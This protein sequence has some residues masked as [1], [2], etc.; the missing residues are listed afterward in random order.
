MS[1]TKLREAALKRG[2]DLPLFPRK[3]VLEPLD[4]AGGFRPIAFRLTN[5]TAETTWLHPDPSHMIWR[6]ERNFEPWEVHG[7]TFRDESHVH[8]SEGYSPWQLLYFADALDM[9]HDRVRV[10]WVPKDECD[11]AQFFET[12]RTSLS[13]RLQNFDEEWTPAIKLLTAMQPRLWPFRRQRVTLLRDP[14]RTGDIDQVEEVAPTFDP[15]AFLRRFEM[16]L[17]ELALLHR[18]FVAE[19]R[20]LDPFPRWY[21][22]TEV[23][24]RRVTDEMTGISLRARDLYDAAWVLRGLYHLATDRWL[25]AADELDDREVSLRR[26][27]LPRRNQIGEPRRAQLKE[28]LLHEGLYPH[29]IHFF[30][31][32]QT[33]EIVLKRLLKLL[34]FHRPGSGVAVTNMRGV[35]QAQRHEVLFRSATEVAA[36]TV[37]IGD[38]EG[39]LSKVLERLRRDGLFPDANDVLLWEL[40]GRPADFEEANFSEA[41]LLRAVRS[42]ARRRDATVDIGLTVSDLREERARQTRP[43]RPAPALTKLM[44]KMAEERGARISKPELANVLAD[45]LVREIRQAGDL[46][47][48]RERRPLLDHL[49]RWLVH[50]PWRTG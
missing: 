14:T 7:W 39:T 2:L 42:A 30:V 11:R 38:R 46:N 45:K 41:E 26:Q 16:T 40:E 24:P 4:R 9:Y 37:L 32:G 34:G 15:N 50:E 3:D 10:D 20:R 48:A 27:H 22:L 44:L 29:R 18:A 23:A 6:E 8:V 19:A 35:D 31:E 28:L 21:S 5:Y 43:R 33:E 1:A 49:W 13:K 25:P 36:R 17:D 47:S 12:R